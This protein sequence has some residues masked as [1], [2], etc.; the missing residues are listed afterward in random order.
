[1]HPGLSTR[2][3]YLKNGWGPRQNS[4]S[5]FLTSLLSGHLSH[6]HSLVPRVHDRLLLFMAHVIYVVDRGV[7]RAPQIVSTFYLPGIWQGCT[8]LIAGA[9]DVLVGPR[10]LE[11]FFQVGCEKKCVIS[12]LSHWFLVWGPPVLHFFLCQFDSSIQD[13]VCPN[14]LCPWVAAV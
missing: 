3:K 14:S 4:L 8:S 11:Q 5:V 13:G 10:E 7:I 12:R 2:W 9:G 6:Y 1:M